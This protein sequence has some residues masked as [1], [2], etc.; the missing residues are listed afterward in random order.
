VDSAILTDERLR[1]AL[2]GNQPSRER[3]CLAVLSLDRNYTE[4]RPRRP[5]G[6]PDGSR[7]IDCLRLGSRCFG[8]VGFLNS[9]SDSPSD[10]SDIKKK[11]KDD[12]LAARRADQDLKSFV[13]LCNVD[14][15]P[16]EVKE[17]EAFAESYEY[18]STDIYWRERLRHV[19]DGPEGLGIRYQ[20][21]SISLSEA[22]QAAFFSRYGKE[23][24]GLVR[25]RFDRIE[26]RL[27]EI[28]YSQWKSGF[29]T[30]IQLDVAF[31][32]WMD[33]KQPSHEHF[34]ACLELQG[35]HS[36]RR[37][38]IIGGRDDHW[39]TNDGQFFFDTKTFFW[40][41]QVG[42]YRD[43]WIPKETRV[44]GGIVTGLSFNLRW[45]PRSPVLVA[46]FDQLN[47]TLHFT[48]NLTVRL[49]SVRFMIDD[50]IFKDYELQP[51]H[52][53]IYAPSLGWPEYSGES[54]QLMNWRS[55]DLGGIDLSYVPRKHVHDDE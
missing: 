10:K 52:F 16:T 29:I 9:V 50:Y 40:R 34:R 7:D 43:S 46:E 54:Q 30:S 31:R 19:L 44:G 37:S 15:T 49:K 42:E 18:T 5:E 45:R 4:V 26:R 6:G 33:S 3:M 32:T 48:E 21:L 36:E 39:A 8:A 25:G 17:L 14:L 55:A 12:V 41:Q 53:K 28:Q 51:E 1:T 38:I 22:E 20:Y 13:F 27:D 47:A 2:N 23:L 24:E 35:V 11:F